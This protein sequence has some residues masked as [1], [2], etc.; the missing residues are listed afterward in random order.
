MGGEVLVALLVTRV[1][2]DEVK[3]LS[4]DDEGS[5]HF[6]GDDGAGQD[7]STDGDEAGERALL[8]YFDDNQR[9]V[10]RSLFPIF[11]PSHGI[12]RQRSRLFTYPPYSPLRFGFQSTSR[13]G[14]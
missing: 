4:S 3:V 14:M 1:L 11:T 8:V 5:V 6:R 12:F 10:N 2:G 7:T 9:S 13:L